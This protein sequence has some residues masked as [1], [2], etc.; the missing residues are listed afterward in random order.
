MTYGHQE[1][2]SGGPCPTLLGEVRSVLRIALTVVGGIAV[3]VGV[4]I[5]VSHMFGPV[6]ALITVQSIVLVG[7]IGFYT[8][9]IH[10]SKLSA[11]EQRQK[12]QREMAKLR[13]S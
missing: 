3:L 12:W 6:V 10:R 4:A 11:W 7:M 1:N 13:K 8:W 5:G 2:Q 9:H